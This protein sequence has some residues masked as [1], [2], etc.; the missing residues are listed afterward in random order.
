VSNFRK[1]AQIEVN[2]KFALAP[3]ETRLQIK[4]MPHPPT[5]PAPLPLEF[6]PCN[7]KK[8]SLYGVK[9]ASCITQCF[10]VNSKSIV[11]ITQKC[12]FVTKTAVEMDNSNQNFIPYYWSVT[13]G[14]SITGSKNRAKLPKCLVLAIRQQFPNPVDTL[15]TLYTKFQEWS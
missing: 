8:C 4:A 1:I 9:F 14:Y 6:V 15:Y 2:P 11:E 12:P 5:D 10:P 3:K 13:N 7:G